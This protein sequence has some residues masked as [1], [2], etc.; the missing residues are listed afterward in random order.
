MSLRAKSNEMLVITFIAAAFAT[1]TLIALGRRRCRK[2]ERGKTKTLRNVVSYSSCLIAASRALES[3]RPDA[4]VVDPLACILADK[5]LVQKREKAGSTDADITWRIAIRTRY[6]D[7]FIITSLAHGHVEQ[8]VHLGSGMDSRVYRLKVP[9][10][11]VFFEIDNSDVLE[12]KENLLHNALSDNSTSLE[13]KTMLQ[14]GN[15]RRRAISCNVEESGWK[16]PLL[17]AGFDP[18]KPTCWVLEGLTYYLSND[19]T[20]SGIFLAMRELSAPNSCLIASVASEATCRWAMG[21]K[22]MLMQSWRWGTDHPDKFLSRPESGTWECT[23]KDVVALGDE[24]ANYGRF[25]QTEAA[26]KDRESTGRMS[27]IMYVTARC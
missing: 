3:E 11:T 26:K 12:L 25:Q 2:D 19:E 13:I 7:D 9:D 8:V 5:A 10:R 6:F 15:K 20:V 21:S 4:L 24:R 23:A 18:E 1:A 17:K 14:I 27:G 16:L 22:H